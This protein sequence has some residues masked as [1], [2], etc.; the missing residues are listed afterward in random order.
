MIP[1]LKN[2]D[3]SII[4]SFIPSLRLP[5]L[6]MATNGSTNHAIDDVGD[7]IDDVGDHVVPL[8]INGAEVKTETTFNVI[9]P[10][11]GK[12][13]WRSSSVSKQ[14]AVEAVEAAQAAFPAWSK[15][16]PSTRRDILLKASDILKRRGDEAADYMDRE[17]G[18]VAGMSKFFNVPTSIELLRDAAGRIVTSTGYVPVCLEDGKSGLIYKEPYGVVFGMAP[19]S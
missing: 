14:N 19:W 2:T 6:N 12:V 18:S 16:K 15:T 8:F 5:P 3:K 13:L 11:T 9:S 7:A 4:I 10:A 1:A 17:T